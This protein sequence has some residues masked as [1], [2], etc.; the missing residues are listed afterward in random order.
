VLPTLVECVERNPG[1][2]RVLVHV[3]RA[4]VTLGVLDALALES[5]SYSMLLGGPEFVRWLDDQRIVSNGTEENEQ[6]VLIERTEDGATLH[7]TLNRPQV[8]N[9]YSAR[10]R[11][12]LVDALRLAHAD[13]E[14]KSLILRGVGPSFCSGGD[15]Q[16]FGLNA[17]DTAFAHAVRSTRNAAAELLTLP[18]ETETEARL[19]G[20]CIGAG[21]ELAACA[22]RVVA[23]PSTRMRLP[24]VAMGLIPGAG[25]TVSV[26]RRIGR[27]R[28]AYLA[29]SGTTLDASEALAWGLVDEVS[30]I[31][32][33]T[34][35]N[36]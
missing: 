25:G 2:S 9:A 27:Q 6:P 16:E 31:E 12:G 11:D 29:L 26:T 33:V 17:A 4:G 5:L 8:H 13:C 36:G 1:A 30:T 20:A 35:V 3:L 22:Q 28:M 18:R 23:D 19:H 14:I 15:L 24:E 10:M 34:V 32:R 21:I 7:I